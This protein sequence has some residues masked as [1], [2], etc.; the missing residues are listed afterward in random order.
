[1]NSNSLFPDYSVLE[2]GRTEAQAVR[3]AQQ[4]HEV[5]LHMLV[6]DSD[7]RSVVARL[8]REGIADAM[9]LVLLTEAE[10]LRW[11]GV[12]PVFVEILAAMRR[13][14][15]ANPERIVETWHNQHRLLVLPDDLKLQTETDDFFGTLLAAEDESAASYG[16]RNERTGSRTNPDLSATIEEMERCLVAAVEMMGYRAESGVVLRKYLLEG[17]PA[18]TIV[19]SQHLASP[20]SLY[21]VV[22]KNFCAPLLQGYP[23]KGI[24]LSDKMMQRVKM[25]R[26]ELVYTPA[27]VLSVLSR[28]SPA[29]FLE[30]LGLTLLQRTQAEAFWGGDYI[31]REGEVERCRR[32]L[33][34]LLVSLQFR[35][36]AVREN[37]IRRSMQA[38][39]PKGRTGAALIDQ[40]FLRVLLRSHPCIEEDRKGYRLVS[41]RLNYDCARLARIVYDAHGP[42][43]LADVLAQYERRYMQRPERVSIANVRTRFP[44]VHSVSRG[45]WRWK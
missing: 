27:S 8:R 12:G 15:V 13:Q 32:T 43:T 35:V 25:L 40:N 16:P 26:K 2:T 41:E 4:L 42:I 29:R 20:A 21:R 5:D 1:M 11:P 19:E 24:Q 28:M 23:V 22:H 9:Q 37:T 38:L 36:V 45:V 44:Q 33:R 3:L 17:L 10:V 30:V 34:D 31:V 39:G 7:R 6:T 18:A 14:V